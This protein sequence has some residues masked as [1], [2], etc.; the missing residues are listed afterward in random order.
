[1]QHEA[2]GFDCETCPV[3]HAR[4]AVW[5]ENLDAWEVFMKLASRVVVEHHLGSHV[6]ARLTDDYAPDALEDL[7]ERLDRIQHLLVPPPKADPHA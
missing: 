3:T 1:M 2:D 7:I 5:P 6:F 4:A